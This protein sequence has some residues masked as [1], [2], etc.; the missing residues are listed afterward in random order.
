MAVHSS[1]KEAEAGSRDKQ[2]I[3]SGGKAFVKQSM[4]PNL[5]SGA[6]MVC[7]TMTCHTVPLIAW[8]FLPALSE[9]ESDAGS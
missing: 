4:G 5:V 7:S 9:A 2:D 3:T 6:S 1:L 8:R